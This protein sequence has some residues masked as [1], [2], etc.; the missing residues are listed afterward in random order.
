VT[1]HKILA[2]DMRYLSS[3]IRAAATLELAF[4]S[5]LL[6]IIFGYIHGAL[7]CEAEGVPVS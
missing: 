2:G 7:V 5:R 1:D 4:L 3:N 6:G